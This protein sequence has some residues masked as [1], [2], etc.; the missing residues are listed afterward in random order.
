MN[1]QTGTPLAL[2]AHLRQS[3]G[4]ILTTPVGARV[5][6]RDFGSIL[7]DLVDAP[8]NARTRLQVIAATAT[9]IL[10]WEP[11]LKPAKIDL[12][13]DGARLVLTLTALLK[14]TGES[15]QLRVQLK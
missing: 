2:L 10:K 1:A 12:E 5:M 9:A 3:I 4:K 8:L 13:T 6:R 11:R 7:P 14:S 15:V